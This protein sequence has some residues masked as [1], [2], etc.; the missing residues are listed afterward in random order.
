MNEEGDKAFFREL[1]FNHTIYRHNALL[2]TGMS[3]RCIKVTE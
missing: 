2:N 1:T 3:V